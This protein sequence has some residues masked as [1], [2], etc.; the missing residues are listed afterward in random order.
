MGISRNFPFRTP[1]NY[2]GYSEEILTFEPFFMRSDGFI[3]FYQ[4]RT[5]ATKHPQ[6]SVEGQPST[7]SG[8]LIRAGCLK[9][10]GWNTDE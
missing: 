6:T 3:T 8:A 5:G 4:L 7:G 9:R 10:S 1:Q 2:D